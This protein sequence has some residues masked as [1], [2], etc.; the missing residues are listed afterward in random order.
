MNQVF[1]LKAAPNVSGGFFALFRERFFLFILSKDLRVEYIFASSVRSSLPLNTIHTIMRL[2]ALW[3]VNA[4][5]FLVIANVV[6]G[7]E[8]RGF[9]TAL[10]LAFLWGCI[11]VTIRPILLLLTLPV[12]ILTLGLFTFVVNGFLFWLLAQMVSGFRVTSFGAAI[13]GA[14]LFSLLGWAFGR[15]FRN[16]G[17]RDE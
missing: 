6:P 8:V 13:V 11:G 10:W 12:T 15:A 5:L 14:L 16:N 1:S 17:G 9:G 3:I 4:V 7:I 2:L